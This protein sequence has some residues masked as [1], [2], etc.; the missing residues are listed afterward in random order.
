MGSRVVLPLDLAGLS[1]RAGR[2][3]KGWLMLCLQRPPIGVQAAGGAT[4]RKEGPQRSA[5][6]EANERPA[7]REVAWFW[8]PYTRRDRHRHSSRH[9][10]CHCHCHRQLTLTP[11]LIHSLRRSPIYPSLGARLPAF[12]PVFLSFM[13]SF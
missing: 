4:I 3:S 5:K 6:S 7:E 11:T 2:L 9:C 1:N 12:I 10:H 8:L 13:Q